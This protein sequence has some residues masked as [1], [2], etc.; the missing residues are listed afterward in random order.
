MAPQARHRVLRLCCARR[1]TGGAASQ[2]V[3][4]MNLSYA[5]YYRV[6]GDEIQVWHVPDCRQSLASIKE[7]LKLG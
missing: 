5:I 4:E 3:I 6:E 1:Q 7:R 2:R